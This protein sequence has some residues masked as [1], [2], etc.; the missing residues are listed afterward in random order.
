VT[1][2]VYHCAYYVSVCIH[3]SVMNGCVCTHLVISKFQDQCVCLLKIVWMLLFWFI[4]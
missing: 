4:L 3:L 2:E 1:S